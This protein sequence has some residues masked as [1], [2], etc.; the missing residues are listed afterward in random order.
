VPRLRCLQPCEAPTSARL[1]TTQ[2]WH[3][4]VG[5]ATLVLLLMA[6]T[7][8]AAVVTQR[9]GLGGHVQHRGAVVCESL[10]D[11]RT[12]MRFDLAGLASGAKVYRARLVM[13]RRGRF[14][15]D[16]DIVPARRDAATGRIRTTGRPLRL[17]G[18]W[19]RW[20]DATDAVRKWAARKTPGGALL[21][22]KA[23][24]FDR[25]ATYL[26][27]AYEGRLRRRMPQVSGVR[28]F[29]R[30]GQVFVTFKEIEDLAAGRADLT[31][32]Q[33]AAKVK[34][35]SADGPAPDDT[36]RE[37]RYRIYRH[38][39]PITPASIGAAKLVGE[40]AGGSGYNTHL[41]PSGWNGKNSPPV[42]RVAVEAGEKPQPLPPGV[43]VHVHTVRRNGRG[44]YAVVAAVNG[45]ENTL[46]VG[47]PNAV[48]PVVEKRGYP[49]PVLD[50]EVVT[51][52]RGVKFVQR[53]YSYWC[54]PPLAPRPLRYDVA[55]AYCPD[56]L[57]KPA[58]LTVA[59]GHAWGS[60]PE[61]PR[62]RKTAGLYLSHSS[63]WPNAFWMGINDAYGTLKGRGQGRWQP[64]PQ[65]RQ[66]ALIRWVT[67]NWRVDTSRI[68][69]A[70]GAWGMME[71]ERP[72]V[73]CCLVGWGLP[74]VTKGFQAWDRAVG[75][76]GPPG[77]YAARPAAQD[78][79]RRQDYSAFVAA[80]PKRELP[81]FALQ[82]GWGMHL[83][84]MGWPP[85]PR[86]LRAMTDT[87]RAF[88]ASWDQRSSWGWRATPVHR[89]VVSGQIDVGR[90]RPLP[91]F[92]RCS[93]DDNPG[94]GRLGAGDPNGQINGYVMWDSKTIVDDRY[95]FEITVWL[96]ES[97]RAADCTVDLTPRRCRKFKAAP[98]AKLRWTNTLLPAPTNGNGE[99]EA[100]LVDT[101]VAAGP[102]AVRIQSGRTIAD[103]H[104]L[105]T[106][107]GLLVGKARQRIVITAAG[108]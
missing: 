48:G 19:Y 17:V 68:V 94:S 87:K 44:W 58:R 102:G 107:A 95:R 31:W 76:W 33:F 100:K 23:P 38:D 29:C 30:A 14:G 101:K 55:V 80:D 43:G 60:K 50:R 65:R 88:V 24:R 53:W 98:G 74:E 41:V 70:I 9:W 18:P 93:L 108:H 86:F 2:P 5:L 21:I 54:D 26:E 67:R 73:Y 51:D 89:A 105:A 42:A 103:K 81:Y 10:A 83:T 90:S 11:G 64:F 28:A 82:A 32:K 75:G 92:G 45:V 79:Y 25:A 61:P 57:A 85:F 77:L 96:D 6:C 7:V 37:L 13:A 69:A 4:A 35:W 47:R 99:P 49:E 27:I 34:G 39:R 3:P 20:F 72:G 97:A 40:V 15:E 84:E 16:F 91:A 59:R 62:P 12:L 71:I 63:E 36:R 66:E 1:Q 8:D 52:L 78:P 104:G 46:D 56:L 106:A 22:R